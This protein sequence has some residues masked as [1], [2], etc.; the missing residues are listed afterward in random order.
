MGPLAVELLEA[1]SRCHVAC[2]AGNWSTETMFEHSC[3]TMLSQSH[4][5]PFPLA[6]TPVWWQHDHALMLFPQPD[7]LVLSDR[8]PACQVIVDGVQCAA[9][10]LFTYCC[11][12][13]LRLR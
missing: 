13:S 3:R 7:A 8:G 10:S 5:S 2:A 6:S 11:L 1:R 12:Y 9:P 4:L